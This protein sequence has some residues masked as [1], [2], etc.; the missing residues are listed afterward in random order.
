MLKFDISIYMDALNLLLSDKTDIKAEIYNQI[1]QGDP[2][3]EDLETD[4]WNAAYDKGMDA[5]KVVEIFN[6]DDLDNLMKYI[7]YNEST[8]TFDYSES[9]ACC[10]LK[11]VAFNIP[12][13]FNIDKYLDDIKGEL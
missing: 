12:C 10:D 2:C 9:A 13:E 3:V 11:V 7:R 1:V 6:D 4:V 5:D 8:I